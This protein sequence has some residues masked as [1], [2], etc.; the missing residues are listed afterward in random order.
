[1][2]IKINCEAEEVKDLKVI[3]E[4]EDS[5]EEIG[6]GKN[7]LISNQSPDMNTEFKRRAKRQR[8]SKNLVKK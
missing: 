8:S 6:K 2:E 4:E 5:N 3:N 1:M 7:F